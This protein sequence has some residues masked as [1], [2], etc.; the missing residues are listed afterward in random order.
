MLLQ[1]GL[2]TTRCFGVTSNATWTSSCKAGWFK[3]HW[4][5]IYASK[6]PQLLQPWLVYE[7]MCMHYLNSVYIPPCIQNVV[8]EFE[9]LFWEH[10]VEKHLVVID[11][12]C[13]YQLYLEHQAEKHQWVTCA[14]M[15]HAHASTVSHNGC[16]STVIKAWYGPPEKR[17]DTR[18]AK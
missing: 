11:I 15:Q 9:G 10:Q 5:I 17:L 8:A 16:K 14:R 18:Q 13:T 6:R 4:S 12:N 1:R 3:G 2:D 7:Y